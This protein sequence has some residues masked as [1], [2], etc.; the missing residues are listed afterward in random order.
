MEQGENRQAAT[1]PGNSAWVSASAGSGKTTLLVERLLRLFLDG[2]EPSR[3]LCLTYTNAG[4]VEMQERVFARAKSWVNLD[5]GALEAELAELFGDTAPPDF[6]VLTP[7]AR[8]LFSRLVD[9]P[10]PL[11]IYT[12]H[13]FC[14]SVL[15]RF[16]IEAG[17]SPHFKVIEEMD[18]ARLL[19]DAYRAVM[20]ALR[21]GGGTA[22][23]IMGAF[24]VIAENASEREFDGLRS[25]VIAERRK[26]MEL[27]ARY[28]DPDKLSEAL[29]SRI[30]HGFKSVVDDH[31]KNP[32]LFLRAAIARIPERELKEYIDAATDSK[33][34]TDRKN[35]AALAE[36]LSQET[37]DA[38]LARFD[39]YKSVFLTAKGAVRARVYT[40]DVAGRSPSLAAALDAEAARIGETCRFL[41]LA[42]ACNM[43][44]AVLVVARELQENYAALKAERS[45]MDFDDLIESVDKL[46][47]HPGVSG[48]ILY[49]LDGGISHILIDEAQDTAPIQWNIV[50]T[51]S[52]NFFTAGRSAKDVKSLFSV[53][54]RK[55]SIF[56]FQG[57]DIAS[58]DRHKELFRAKVSEGSFP[59][60]EVP[61]RASF[62]TAKNILA[63]VDAAANHPEVCGL[64]AADEEIRHVARRE[65][66]D[67][68][69]EILPLVRPLSSD[70][71]HFF[72]PPVEAGEARSA[73]ADLS[74]I[75]ARKIKAMLAHDFIP[76]KGGGVR[77]VMPGDI[78]ILVERRANARYIEGKLRALSVP[79][80][81]RDKVDLSKDLTALDLLSTLRF[82]LFPNDDLSLCEA[83]KSPLFGLSDDDLFKLAHARGSKSVFEIVMETEEY[84]GLAALLRR[85]VD[86]ARTDTPYRFF[87][88]LLTI[89]GLRGRFAGRMGAEA[90]DVISEF[91]NKALLYDR[92]KIG[93][94]CAQFLE[95][96]ERGRVEAKRDPEGASA[97]VRVMTAHSAKGLESPIVFLL[98]SNI[99]PNK[100]T[101]RILWED[102][103]PLYSSG[104][105]DD[106]KSAEKASHLE[107]FYRLM[108]VAM[109]R[110]RDR[111]YVCASAPKRGENKESWY[112]IISSVAKDF[113]RVPDDVLAAFPRAVVDKEV[114][115]MGEKTPRPKEVAEPAPAVKSEAVP[116]FF[117]TPASPPAPAEEDSPA[118][119]PLDAAESEASE[120]GIL[121]HKLLEELSPDDDWKVLAARYLD[122]H[123]AP[124]KE[125]IL[126]ALGRVFADE[127]LRALLSCPA[128]KEAEIIT[129]SQGVLRPDRIVYAQGAVWI[130]DYKTDA[131][132]RRRDR[133]VKQLAR[134][135][136]A[137]SAIDPGAR[138][139]TAILWISSA[140]LDET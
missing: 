114:L 24:D 98:D 25:L 29:K 31:I 62:R 63:L 79:T 12:I 131:D 20:G 33:A 104:D 118:S 5:D 69:I 28:P 127:K 30:F 80:M 38:R 110:A 52:E 58:F 103:L 137:F 10:L 74:E 32:E 13:A 113:R 66:Y 71:E 81:G 132:E 77:R 11:R 61:L 97:A 60:L 101:A 65:D 9:N 6:S 96:F 84:S 64:K 26:F 8:G 75:V 95:W 17:V 107:E 111:L 117:N 55:Q 68:Y 46:F 122:R 73:L 105:F 139:R 47:R 138:V 89:L 126:A 82:A 44:S 99:S 119:S 40:K 2:V 112:S 85:I 124:Q 106:V 34:S 36:F 129:K 133:H 57:A 87:D 15:K 130:I 1:I 94:S 121:L 35:A 116:E 120:R 43:T 22:A 136:S 16:P 109:T 23:E 67:G 59:F 70:E 54:D 90:E 18:S 27:F 135:K 14:Q 56:G 128:K 125:E 45:G 140:K 78:M 42:R 76:A 83:L 51:L 88:R 115:A 21:R 37:E 100:K 41:R 93:K 134:Y 102:G 50:D 39:A 91:L 123:A 72:K 86:M 108:Y 49:K 19:D 53:G 7:R 48:W 4:A 92:T 3:I